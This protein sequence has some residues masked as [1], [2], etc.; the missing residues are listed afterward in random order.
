MI[1]HMNSTSHL[2]LGF[3]TNFSGLCSFFDT[4]KNIDI[5][6]HSEIFVTDFNGHDL[7]CLKKS[8]S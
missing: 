1:T 6:T 3:L 7:Q 2:E 8:L 5:L 4:Q